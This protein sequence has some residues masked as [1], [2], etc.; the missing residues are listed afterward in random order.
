MSSYPAQFS[1]PQSPLLSHPHSVINGFT[2]I[3]TLTIYPS[4][5]FSSFPGLTGESRKTRLSGSGLESANES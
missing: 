3:T 4:M 2:V 1:V 5:F